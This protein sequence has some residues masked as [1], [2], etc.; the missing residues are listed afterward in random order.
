ME[1]RVAFI[2]SGAK[3][4]GHATVR[5]LMEAGW[6][7]YLT[8][9]QSEEEAQQLL[10]Q[11]EK[12]S[13]KVFAKQVNLTERWAVESAVDDC[14]QRFGR[15]DALIHNFGP[16]VFERLSL[17]DYS[18]EMWRKMFD[19]NLENF[20]WMYRKVIH[21]M[22]R[23]GFGRIVTVGYDGAG[24]ADGWRFRA[25]YAAAKSALAVLT[26]SVAAEERQH[27]VTANMVCPGDIR[28]QNKMRM[29]REVETDGNPIL[30]PPVGEDVARLIVFL[31]DK[32][33]QQLNGTVTEVTGGYDPLA[34][35][36]GTD[37]LHEDLRF[38]VGA[39]VYVYPWES[40]ATV[41][42]IQ[43]TPNRN[44]VYTVLGA[45]KRGS[46]TVH[47]LAEPRSSKHE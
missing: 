24:T 13:R 17:A 43:R 44:I 30:R 26:K 14:Y 28:G 15:I 25:A 3:G 23:E 39:K 27:G 46:F 29:I 18:D 10:F 2:T 16:F 38:F 40:H 22:R 41:T 31:C 1:E 5:A 47:Q 32:L 19:G 42:E 21:G 35:D 12:L 20:F 4:L 6:D 7:V 45:L 9:G 36:D 34:Y 11:A 33:S 37:V 8:Y